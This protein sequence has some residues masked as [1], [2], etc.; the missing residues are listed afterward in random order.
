MQ[1]EQKKRKE[2]ARVV[3]G[4]DI[5]QPANAPRIHLNSASLGKFL[6]ENGKVCRKKEK[7]RK[8]VYIFYVLRWL[9][10]WPK[11]HGLK[12]H[13]PGRLREPL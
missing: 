2:R 10:S 1:K 8:S 12:K 5:A 7:R 6:M 11:K 3:V 13:P 4:L 9:G